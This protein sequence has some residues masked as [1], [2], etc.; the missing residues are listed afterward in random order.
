MAFRNEATLLANLSHPHL[1]HIHDHFEEHGC[2]YPIMDYIDGETLESHLAKT[3]DGKS[4]LNEVIKI[5]L[6]LCTVLGYLHSHQP[7]IIFRDLK[8]DNVMLTKDGLGSIE[9]CVIIQNK[10]GALNIATGSAIELKKMSSRNDVQIQRIYLH[11]L[12]LKYTLFHMH[13]R[14]FNAYYT[15]SPDSKCNYSA[16]Q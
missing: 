15:K 10:R 16:V 9:H 5:A 1:P 7:P 2:W 12:H 13:Q 14:N 8:P 3:P 11:W 4:A 6:Q